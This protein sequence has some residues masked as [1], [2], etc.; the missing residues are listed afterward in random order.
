MQTRLLASI[1]MQKTI[2]SM[3]RHSK[4]TETDLTASACTYVFTYLRKTCLFIGWVI[5][6]VIRFFYFH[7][8][9][10]IEVSVL[11]EICFWAVTFG[12]KIIFRKIT[13]GG[14]RCSMNKITNKY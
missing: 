8:Y 11:C 6:N 12:Y 4:N 13:V 14:G 1:Y 9:V 5:Y 7:N 2:Y 3:C 10:F